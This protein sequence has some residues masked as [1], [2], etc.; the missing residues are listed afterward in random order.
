[1]QGRRTRSSPVIGKLLRAASIFQ[2]HKKKCFRNVIC[3]TFLNYS[4]FPLI[5]ISDVPLSIIAGKPTSNCLGSGI[6]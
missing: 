4:P 3:K 5:N 1:M 2:K 6:G